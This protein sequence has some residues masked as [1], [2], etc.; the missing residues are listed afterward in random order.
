SISQNAALFSILGTYYGG[1]GTTNFA[2]PDLRGRGPLHQGQGSG[3]SPYSIGEQTG[4][5]AVTLLGSQLPAHTHVANASTNPADQ[6]SPAGAVWAALLD[7]TP[8]AGTSFTKTAA[9]T[10]MAPNAVATAGSGQ[11]VGVIQPYL[12][13]SFIIALVGIFPSRN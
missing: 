10:T 7:A 8:A 1:N 2:L 11:P 12:C 6:N 9:N 5:E 13:V 3:L 4:V